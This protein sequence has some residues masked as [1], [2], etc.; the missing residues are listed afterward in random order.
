MRLQSLLLRMPGI[1]TSN[2]KFIMNRVE[3][4]HELTTMTLDR[5][6]VCWLLLPIV[7]PSCTLEKHIFSVPSNYFCELLTLIMP[8]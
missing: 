1:N 7:A 6:K 3:N 2:V 5:L 4:L 8:L